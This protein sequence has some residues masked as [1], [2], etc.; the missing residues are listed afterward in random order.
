[1]AEGRRKVSSTMSIISCYGWNTLESFGLNYFLG[2]WPSVPVQTSGETCVF[3]TSQHL[4]VG[5]N[6][7]ASLFTMTHGISKPAV[8]PCAQLGS[9]GKFNALWGSPLTSGRKELN[10]FSE[11]ILFLFLGGLP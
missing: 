3:M 5:T 10:I 7:G 11:Y 9:A 8:L 4:F 1:M 6:L 2:I